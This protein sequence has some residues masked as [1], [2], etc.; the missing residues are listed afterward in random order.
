MLTLQFPDISH[1]EDYR[2]LIEDWK[3]DEATPTS[4][5]AL[6]KWGDNYESFL[7]MINADVSTQDKE[8]VP[9]SL[10]F[11]VDKVTS[12]TSKL[13]GALQ[14][15]H[16]IDHPV[17]KYYWWHIGYWIA[18]WDRENWYGSTMLKLWLDKCRELQ[19]A[20]GKVMLTCDPDNVW[21]NKIIQKNGWE[22]ECE[23]EYE[24]K[25]VNR[26]WIKL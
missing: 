3:K 16:H 5:A 21:S 25:M 10:Y 1:K 4:P 12:T 26:Y 15:R 17:L 13:V 20:W 19:I 22:L 23:F 8:R 11:L 7:S 14:I 2:R 9:A 18:P 6:F 24:W